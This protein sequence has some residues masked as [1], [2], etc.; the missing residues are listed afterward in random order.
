M[1][2]GNRIKE[3]YEG[4]GYN[5]PLVQSLLEYIL[6]NYKNAEYLKISSL[7]NDFR[8]SMFPVIFES[9]DLK[10]YMIRVTNSMNQMMFVHCFYRIYAL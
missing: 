5:K 8:K 9:G 7:W 6:R 2:A 4:K 10:T 3:A 1:L